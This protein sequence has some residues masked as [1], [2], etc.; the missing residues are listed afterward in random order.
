MNTEKYLNKYRKELEFKNYSKRSIDMYMSVVYCFLRDFDGSFTEPEKISSEIIKDWI[1]QASSEATLRIR[2]GAL[3]NFYK[4]VIHQPLKF[5]YIEYPRKEKRLPVILDQSEIQKIY[6]ELRNKKH[7]A[8]LLLL[9]STGIRISELLHLKISDIDT[10]QMIIFIRQ[11]KGKKDR[12]VPLKPN[13]LSFIDEYSVEYAPREY[14][15]NGQ[16]SLIYSERSVNQFLKDASK[17]AGITKKVHAHLIRHC[18][19]TGMLESGDDLHTV[20]K[21][22]GHSKPSTTA[23]YLHLAP[24]YISKS[25]NH[26]NSFKT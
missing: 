3:K 22:A 25:A 9:Y 26:T 4:R 12:I 21:N 10:A 18:A 20:Q 11:G 15:F 14:L 23:I 24:S 7:K 19:L 17:R 5:K 2:I 1:K 13:V 8:I 6:D 16:G